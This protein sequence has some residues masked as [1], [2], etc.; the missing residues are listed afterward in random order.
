MSHAPRIAALTAAIGLATALPAFAE[1]N[2]GQTDV[3][4]TWHG[5]YTVV[6]PTNAR[7]D[8]PRFNEAEWQ[9]H[10]TDQQDNVFYGETKFRR[11]GSDSWNTRQ[12]TGNLSADGEGR[13]GMLE[14]RTEPPYE[15]TGVIDG[16]LDGDKIYVD[17]R[18][19]NRGATYSAVLEKTDADA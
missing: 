1:T 17:F 12:V 16:R 5:E 14:T 10:I 11:Q 3:T 9:L 4:G 19:L 15:V 18:S 2:T 13:I 7:G 6:V 8:G